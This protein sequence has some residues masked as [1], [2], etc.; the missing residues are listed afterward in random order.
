MNN[1]QTI[2]EHIRFCFSRVCEWTGPEGVR[3]SN[4]VQ[5]V[6][7]DLHVHLNVSTCECLL[8]IGTTRLD[9]AGMWSCALENNVEGDVEGNKLCLET[10]DIDSMKKVNKVNNCLRL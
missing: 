9:H 5:H 7:N 10:H 1:F 6:S 8:V 3:V 2:S 4:A